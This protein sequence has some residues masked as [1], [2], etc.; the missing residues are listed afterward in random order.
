MSGGIDFLKISHSSGCNIRFTFTPLTN[1]IPEPKDNV[2]FL[3]VRRPS[4]EEFFVFVTLSVPMHLTTLMPHGFFAIK[5]IIDFLPELID[6]CP[7]VSLLII[8]CESI[9]KFPFLLN[10]LWDVAH[11]TLIPTG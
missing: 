8:G 7:Q 1:I 5:K 10:F 2:L 3:S 9:E 6:L 4:I 11:H